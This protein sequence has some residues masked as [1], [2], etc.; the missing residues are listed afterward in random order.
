MK[1]IIILG[2]CGS[3]GTQTLDIIANYP[4]LFRVVGLSLGRDLKLG[5]KLIDQYKPEI[6]CLRNIE[7]KKDIKFDGEIVIGDEGLISLAQYKTTNEVIFVNAL[8]GSS[9]LRPTVEAIKSR[10]DIALANKETLVLAGDII[11]S[12]VKEYNVKLHPID[13]EHSA[14]WQCLRGEDINDVKE[15]IITASGGS[16]RDKTREE[17]VNVTKENALK[18]PNWSMGSK[19]TIDSATMMNKGF[20]IIEAHF[21][22]NLP[23]E[24]IK[25][26]L[27]RQS[28]VHSLV[29]F[30]DTSIKANLGTPD[31]RIPILYALSYPKHYETPSL[32]DLILDGLTLTFEELSFD[33]YPMVR[34]A[35][36]ALE[37][38][39]F[40]LVALN[41]ANEAAVKLFLKDKIKFL[42]I[43]NIVYEY[44]QKEY[45]L[46]YNIDNIIKL[47]YEI[48][49][50]ILRK[51]GE[52]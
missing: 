25:P 36:N 49:Q 6:I 42:D 8:V 46:E 22:F 34:Y 30:N 40:Y 33:R 21:L 1:D 28:I 7:H 15:L 52:K 38:K 16:F 17:L 14:I 29:R 44:Q 23:L 45:N 32:S 43:E 41:A 18:H 5:Q 20:E 19:I 31:M 35:Y 12:L 2:A 37:K 47:D 9:G 27:H 51:Y 50:E 13:S 24:K 10:K 26:I 11:N 48:Q 3:I 39:G 4:S